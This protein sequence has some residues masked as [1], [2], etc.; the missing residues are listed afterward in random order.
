MFQSLSRFVFRRLGLLQPGELAGGAKARHHRLASRTL[1]ASQGNAALAWCV[2]GGRAVRA[3]ARRPFVELYPVQWRR[4]RQ[5]ALTRDAGCRSASLVRTRALLHYQQQN[6][7][8][9]TSTTKR[10]QRNETTYK[11]SA[12]VGDETTETIRPRLV[13]WQ[14]GSSP[15]SGI[16]TLFDNRDMVEP[17]FCPPLSPRSAISHSMRRHLAAG[18]N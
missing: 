7:D 11:T 9:E 10:R 14:R 2:V 13:A 3:S 4:A 6:V 18:V 5:P 12:F 1:T 8:N 17:S 16:V 15:Q